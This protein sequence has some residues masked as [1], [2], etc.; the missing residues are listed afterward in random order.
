[1]RKFAFWIKISLILN[2]KICLFSPPLFM[3]GSSYKE[4]R[5]HFLNRFGFKYG[6]LMN[7]GEFD[8]TSNWGLSFTVWDKPN[9]IK[10]DF[11]LNTKHSNDDFDIVN[12]HNKYI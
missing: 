8:G 3:T 10:N 2:I 5:N 6:F 9:N 7:A 1:M 11:K 12:I 4:F